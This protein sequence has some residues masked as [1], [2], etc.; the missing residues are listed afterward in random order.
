[1]TYAYPSNLD[2]TSCDAGIPISES[3]TVSCA[4]DKAYYQT[5]SD[6]VVCDD[7][8]VAYST[9]D[10]DGDPDTVMVAPG[11]MVA[12]KIV[13]GGTNLSHFSFSAKL[14]SSHLGQTVSFIGKVYSP[15]PA[16]NA[17]NAVLYTSNSGIAQIITDQGATP[18][19][20]FWSLSPAAILT[21]G[22]TY[23]LALV[24]TDSTS[25]TTGHVFI[26]QDGALTSTAYATASG[27]YKL[28]SASSW[29]EPSS[30]QHIWGIL[31]GAPGTL[32][33]DFACTGM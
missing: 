3:C 2:T 23:W 6:I 32:T 17:P 7:S 24:R 12:T 25:S 13:I 22:T 15:N 30:T 11:Q 9:P 10:L 29:S 4:S 26:G 21:A 8:V 28:Y 1:M 18:D 33:S 16:T 31:T 5:G 27:G 19:F 14:V 20:T